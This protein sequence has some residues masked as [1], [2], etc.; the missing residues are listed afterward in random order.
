MLQWTEGPKERGHIYHQR[1]VCPLGADSL[2]VDIF[3]MPSIAHTRP[4]AMTL[5][6]YRHGKPMRT[7]QWQLP[8]A[9][10]WSI[11]GREL[12]ALFTKVGVRPENV[13]VLTGEVEQLLIRE[14]PALRQA[15]AS[16]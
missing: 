10:D 8:G 14:T 12:P 7:E 11:V 4:I 15:L 9:D 13:A 5:G 2:V 6:R 16:L 3:V 1:G